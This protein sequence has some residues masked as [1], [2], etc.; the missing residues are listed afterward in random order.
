[1]LPWFHAVKL[2]SLSAS[3]RADR[4]CWAAVVC[5]DIYKLLAKEADV[6]LARQPPLPG[7]E[8]TGSASTNS[9]SRDGSSGPVT[10]VWD[11]TDAAAAGLFSASAGD[12]T[13]AD[14]VLQGVETYTVHL[15][16][17]PL[18]RSGQTHLHTACNAC[19]SCLG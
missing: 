18:V 6:T 11:V 8:S 10:G 2:G 5:R 7:A 12:A 1:V 14:G 16:P 9:S 13:A 3:R 17:M 15:K 4:Q 19:A